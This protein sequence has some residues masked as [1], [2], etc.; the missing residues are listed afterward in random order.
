MRI[1]FIHTLCKVDCAVE[2]PL[3]SQ[4][5]RCYGTSASFINA[6]VLFSSRILCA[7]KSDHQRA[8]ACFLF[9]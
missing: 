2:D 4:P 6:Y 7:H 8:L 9:Q 5:S 3:I 1:Y